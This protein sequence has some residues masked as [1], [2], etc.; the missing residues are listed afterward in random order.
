MRTGRAITLRNTAQERD[1]KRLARPA[2]TA[3]CMVTGVGALMTASAQAHDEPQAVDIKFAA[4]AGDQP[5]ACGTLIDGL[6]TTAQAAQLQDFRFFVSE[7]KLTRADGKSVAVKLAKNSA[8]RYTRNGV[9]VTLIDLENGAGDC[10]VDGTRGMNASV[11]GTVPHGKYV[12]VS[13][14][15]GVPF[16]LNHTDAAATPAPL[17]SVAMGWSWQ[18]GHKFT[19]IEVSDPGGA[20]G[21]WTSKTFYVHLGS[22]GCEGNPATGQAVKCGAP[23]R[24]AVR[25]KKFNPAKQQVA[26]DLKAV[27]AGTDVTAN[28]SGAPGCMS[29]QTD[30]ECGSVFKA[31]G[32]DWKA[33]GTGTGKPTR[34][35]AQTIFR[36]VKR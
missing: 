7:V 24:P 18:I 16:A 32:V 5:V 29:E 6:G 25:L 35:T 31:F 26:V 14:S 27:L 33:D 9:G 22:A 36:A 4:M 19:K 8:Y 17:N 2:V 34:S 15:V 11:R 1:M 30:P 3:L 20:T 12:G 13:W 28:Q 23:N 21:S 10:A